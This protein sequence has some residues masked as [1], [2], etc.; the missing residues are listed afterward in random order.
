MSTREQAYQVLLVLFGLALIWGYASLFI[1]GASS[2]LLKSGTRNE[3]VYKTNK[4]LVVLMGSLRG[5][6]E[7]WSTL[8]EHVLDANH[9]DLALLVSHASTRDIYQNASLFHRAKYHWTFPEY[10]DW[11]DAIDLMN[12]GSASWRQRVL[13]YIYEFGYILGGVTSHGNQYGSGAIAFMLRW[14][15]SNHLQEQQDDNDNK[16]GLSLLQTYERFIITR[17]DHYYK[18]RHDIS[19]LDPNYM[20]VPA[21]E[22]Y[23]GITDRHLVASRAQ[24]LP[25]LDIFPPI[26]KDPQRYAHLLNNTYG[27]NVEKIIDY[28]WKEQGLPVQRFS[29]MMFT[30][31]QDGDVTRM[32]GL[33]VPVR[34]GVRLKYEKEYVASYAT[35][36][37]QIGVD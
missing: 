28:R 21:G 31:G 5:G 32:K 17:S 1:T 14:F 23:G 22:D 29:R 27:N 35:C 8:T 10:T 4:T 11:A 19:Q 20:W 12:N 25:A 37:L 15:L 2:S 33:G 16:N 34:E 18:C 6:E 9:A 7:T 13:P 36:G 26:L 30:C 24:V 3:E